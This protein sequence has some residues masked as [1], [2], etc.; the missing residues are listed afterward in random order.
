MAHVKSWDRLC[1]LTDAKWDDVL[2]TEMAEL[3]WSSWLIPS[4]LFL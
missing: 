1:L 2:D 4:L 3:N